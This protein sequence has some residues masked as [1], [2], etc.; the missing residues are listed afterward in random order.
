MKILIRAS[1]ILGCAIW[2]L[3]SAAHAGTPYIVPDNARNL[4]GGRAVEVVVGQAEI[5]SNIN[6]S[7][8][9]MAAGGGLLAGLV[10]SAVNAEKAKKAE[11]A[12]T[13]LRDALHGVDADGL[14]VTTTQNALSHI[15]W[16]PSDAIKFSKDSTPS[17]KSAFLDSA[18]AAHA[19]FFDYSYDFTPDFASVRVILHVQMA[20]TAP[21]GSTPEAR[22]KPAK[23]AYAQTITSMVQLSV[24][25]KSNDER[26]QLW[27][28]G[29]GKLARSALTLAFSDIEQVLPRVL[30]LTDSEY[31]A[32]KG[33]RK[34]FAVDAQAPDK[35]W[36]IVSGNGIF[37]VGILPVG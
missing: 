14:A 27:A 7:N 11:A 31:N 9:G 29:D 13:P 37:M 8:I 26:I 20:N 5:G 18:G 16:I 21:A 34:G 28:A 24:T 30:Q 33:L 3:L 36:V 32:V 12:I 17:G 6:P 35:G 10:E 22:L 15:D 23:L 1:L 25:T 19:V 2:L 4:T